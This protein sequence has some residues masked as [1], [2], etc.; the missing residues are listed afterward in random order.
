[1]P[2]ISEEKLHFVREL[3]YGRMY[4]AREIAST[5]NVSI[6]AVYYFMRHHSIVRRNLSEQNKAV[7]ERK[8]PSF[9]LKKKLSNEEKKLKTIGT[10]LYW[11]EGYKTEKA[12]GVD[13]ANSDSAM[14]MIF[15]EFLRKVCGIDNTRLRIFLYCYAD[16]DKERLM[17]F[18]STLLDV[19]RKQ[20]TKPYTRKDFRKEKSGKMPHG[21]VHVRYSDKKLLTVIKN[22]I[23]EHK[24]IYCVGT[25]VVNEGKL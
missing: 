1:M 9:H 19:P 13:F 18:W 7:F 4:S 12:M 16:Q 10:V 14:V 23:E 6:D 11:G 15:T 17:R 2:A 8:Q 22:W 24:K 25:Q 21:L 5:L 3:Y 20:F